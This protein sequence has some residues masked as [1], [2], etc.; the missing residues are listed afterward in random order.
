M[1]GC[2]GGRWVNVSKGG[3]STY[4][5]PII[6]YSFSMGDFVLLDYLPF[7]LPMLLLYPLLASLDPLS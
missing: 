3:E 1:S 7:M 6:I 5:V 2:V 4:H